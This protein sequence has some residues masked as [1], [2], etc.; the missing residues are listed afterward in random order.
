[1]RF[2]ITIFCLG[3][4]FLSFRSSG[5][6]L[7]NTPPLILG[8]NPVST[9][10]NVPVGIS[11]NDLNVLDIDLND[12]FYPTGFTLQVY[13]G[14]NYTVQGITVHPEQNFH[15]DL[16]VPVTVNDGDD[17]SNTFE[18]TV[19][20]IEVDNVKPTIT[21]QETLNTPENTSITLTLDNLTVS[22]PDNTYPDDF[23]LKV[24]SG[25]N[26]DHDENV[27]TPD[28]GF[29]GD[30]KVKVRVNDGED[31]SD[32][33]EITITVDPSPNV[34]PQ[35][36]GQ[37]ALSTLEATP[38]TLAL[39]DLTIVDPDNTPADFRLIVHAGT[40]Y[41][42]N[43]ATVTPNA[44]ITGELTVQVSVSD[45][46]AESA[47]YPLKITVNAKPNVPPEI[48][49][50]VA[51]TTPQDVPIT[52]LL[53]NLTIVDPDS[54]PNDFR[55]ALYDG[56]GYTFT[57]ATVI[58]N[59]G[60]TGIIRVPVSVSDGKAESAKFIVEIDVTPK[61]NEIPRITGQD[62]LS[63][64]IGTPIA[65]RVNNVRVV[66]PDN[67]FPDDFTLKVYPGQNYTFDNNNTITPNLLFIGELKVPV[68]VFDG[69]NESA[70]WELIISVNI[71]PNVQPIIIGQNAINGLSGVPL[72]LKLADLLVLDTDDKYPDDF[73]MKVSNGDHYVVT[74]PVGKTVTITPEATFTGQLKVP[75]SVNDGKAESATYTLTV[76]IAAPPNQVPQITGQ[77][78]VGI[79]EDQQLTP[80]LGMLIVKDDDNKYPADFKLK[81][82]APSNNSNYTVSG[83]KIIPSLNYNGELKVRVAV[84]DGEA[85]SPPYE[86]KVGVKPV[87]DAPVVTG[88]KSLSTIVSTPITIVID[89]IIVTDPDN[90]KFTLQVNDGIAY[91]HTGNTVTPRG[92]KAGESFEVNIIV[93]DPAQLS[94][95]PAT[96]DISVT[97]VPNTAP[98]I[99]GQDPDPLVTT[100]NTKLEIRISDLIITDPDR[101]PSSPFTLS[102]LAGTNYTVSGTSILP[103]NNYLGDLIVPVTVSDGKDSS[104]PYNVK[105]HVKPPSATPQIVGQDALTTNEDEAITIELNDLIVTDTDDQYPKGFTLKLLDGDDYTVSGRLITPA[106]DF[107]GYLIASVTVTDDD[108]KTSDPYGLAIIVNPVDDA[109]VITQLETADLY[110]Q[111]GDNPVPLTTTLEVDD[112]D[113]DYLS[114]AEIGFLDGTYSRNYDQL[115][116]VNTTNLR[117]VFD[118]DNGR[119]SLIGYAPLSEYQDA[120]RSVKYYYNLNEQPGTPQPLPG[121][122]TFYV[123][124]HDGQK[125]SDS[126]SRNIIMDTNVTLKIPAAFSPNDDEVNETWQVIAVTNADQCENAV[127]KV[128][129]K[130]GLLLFQSIGIK[131]E[132]DGKYNGELLP[133]DTYYYTV[134]LKLSYTTKTYRGAVTLLR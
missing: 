20:V 88:Q 75:V 81:I 85:D 89:D 62:V 50:Q 92:V 122:R 73:T 82:L 117:G 45:G 99:T 90:D 24:G 83:D 63:T 93:K 78:T 42:V 51:L 39:G 74:N 130:K 120:I 21:G 13:D 66:D 18:M 105:V 76:N 9:N 104:N 32:E 91:S 5:Q 37:I 115:Q 8:Q 72:E 69:K 11:L 110:Y 28:D 57:N 22:D 95:A 25:Q 7:G 29:S 87:N 98:I 56:T 103:S 2:I 6:I 101:S 14:D 33:I 67:T 84:N 44:G 55:L 102:I 71:I 111:P 49:G 123:N 35:I 129:D 40:G 3:I 112:I 27:I 106:K 38:I 23:T 47:Q 121:N 100:Q 31:D 61:P 41:A 34:A 124:V 97:E 36:N 116:F 59:A 68:T 131:K 30:L 4:V 58:P 86:L 107:Y 126:L 53:A 70:Q 54:S 108:G 114:F 94:S 96:I 119:L 109:P 16:K 118:L 128:Y 17:N 113:S 127:V 80:T 48:R 1:M 65:L 60:V 134:D 77:Q 19:T 10:E 52:L 125:A 15:G 133:V 12:L 64:F 46:Q 43:D 132:W 26:Y 79:D